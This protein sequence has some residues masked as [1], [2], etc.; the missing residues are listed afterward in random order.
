MRLIQ[1]DV[2]EVLPT[3]PENHFQGVLTDPPYGLGT[4]VW[5][6]EVPGAEVWRQ[7]TRVLTPGHW[8]LAFGGRRSLHRLMG[9]MEEGGIE[10]RDLLIW[11]YGTGMPI[12]KTTLRPAFEPLVLARAPGP[13]VPLGIDVCRTQ[14]EVL[15]SDHRT[16][17]RGTKTAWGTEGEVRAG[18][19]H[20]PKGR[21][22]PNVLLGHGEGCTGESCAPGCPVRQLEAQREGATRFFYA[23]FFCVPKP[24]GREAEGNPHP[25]KKPVRL[26]PIWLG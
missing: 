19:R 17:P 21:W 10:L 11:L 12:G 6:E 8:V 20:H 22:P 25:T 15:P 7:I 4:A 3:F 26:P 24:P 9:E 13:A 1:G 14:G 16:A 23:P 5:D 2:R 18:E